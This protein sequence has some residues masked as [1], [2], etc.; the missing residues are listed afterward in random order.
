[1]T[2]GLVGKKIGMTRIFKDE[3]ASIPITVLDLS[4]NRVAQI[5]SL[6][7]DGYSAIQVA[8]G[9]KSV[10]SKALPKVTG[11]NVNSTIIKKEFRVSED[12]YLSAKQGDILG[13]SIFRVGQKVDISGMSIGKGFSGGGKRHNFSSQRASHGNSVSHNA[14]GS[15]GMA[16]DPGRVFL[17]KKMA[18]H[19]GFEQCTQQNIEIVHVDEN[20]QLLFVKGAVPGAK[21]TNVLVRH[22]VKVRK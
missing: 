3:G 13:V 11:V 6:K 9:F 10:S 18:G 17:G 2:L 5:K 8:F 22:A 15:T 19:L 21:G 7:I 1:M 20:R 4:N 12:N 14:P 16:Q